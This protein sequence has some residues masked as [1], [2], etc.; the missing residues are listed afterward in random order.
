M[1]D[2]KDHVLLAA[3]YADVL[4]TMEKQIAVLDQETRSLEPGAFLGCGRSPRDGVCPMA[5][6]LQR[7]GVNGRDDRDQSR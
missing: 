4:R 7:P 3:P 6:M 2:V 1:M 5:R